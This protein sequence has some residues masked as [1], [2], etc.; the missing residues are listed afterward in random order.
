MIGIAWIVDGDD[1]SGNE[2]VTP[3]LGLH[4]EPPLKI[5]AGA[6]LVQVY[7]GLIYQGPAVVKRIVN[8]LH[9]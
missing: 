2:S 6:T 3:L 7:T 1:A 8:R 9:E 5:D 4:K